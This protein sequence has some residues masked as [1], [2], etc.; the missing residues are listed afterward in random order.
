MALPEPT[1]RIRENK[2]DRV[3]FVLENVDL[4]FAN[5][6]RRVMMAD[7]P[8]LAIDIVELEMNTSV[9]PDEFIA[10]RLGMVPLISTNCEEAIRYNRDCTCEVHCDFCTVSLMLDVTC[11]ED[12]NLDVT[13]N[14]LDVIPVN[15]TLLNDGEGGEEINKR[16]EKFG[17]PVGQGEPGVHPVLICKMRPG[18]QIKARCIAKK[19]IAKEHAKWSPCSAVAF[20][21][22]PYNKLRHTSYW[23]EEDEKAEWPLSENAREEEPP[24]EDESF[25]YNAKPEKFY[26]DVETVGSLTPQEVVLRVSPDYL[27]AYVDNKINGF[28]GHY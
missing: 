25:D 3:N 10:H 23:F 8:T 15:Y 1:V 22:D 20:E 28:I 16:P 19:G 17:C 5:S 11:G 21:Y 7:V 6:I 9:L 4:S 24:R 27:R 2:K 13:S 26:F 18:Q 12:G 14:H